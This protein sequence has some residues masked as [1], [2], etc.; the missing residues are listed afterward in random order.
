MDSKIAEVT[1]YFRNK[2][3]PKWSAVFFITAVCIQS[4]CISSSGLTTQESALTPDQLPLVRSL[5][6]AEKMED[7][8]QLNWWKKL[9]DPQLSELITEA[10]ANS[11]DLAAADARA[12][13][14]FA[15][16]NIA[17]AEQYPTLDT[18]AEETGERNSAKTSGSNAGHFTR[19]HTLGLSFNWGIDLWGTQRATWLATLGQ[20]R[21]AQIETVAAR[22]QVSTNVARAYG[23]LAYAYT[24]LDISQSEW[25]RAQRILSLTRQ[26][27]KQGIDNDTARQRAET[28][29]A[30]AQQQILA[31]KRNLTAANSALAALI[32]RG[33]D[34]ALDIQRPTLP[35]FER[36]GLPDD[37]PA[38]LLN[39]RADLLAARWQIESN[40]Q[41][42]KAATSLFLP[43]ISLRALAGVASQGS[44]NLFS[45]ASRN[46]QIAPTINLPIFDGGRLRANL[47]TQ[48]ALYDRAI[49]GYNKTL[50]NALKEVVVLFDASSSF[51]QQSTQQQQVTTLAQHTWQLA[52]QRYKRGVGS[53]LEVLSTQQ[54]LFTAKQ[55]LAELQVQQ[56][57][58]TVQL[59]AALGGGLAPSDDTLLPPIPLKN[60]QPINQPAEVSYE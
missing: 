45:W 19:D 27:L 6:Q 1:L 46:Y 58:N 33:P 24:Q 57:D 38:E 40:H 4:G 23:Q 47:A 5:A 52:Q 21:V 29:V 26:R 60:T 16:A 59:I 8:P 31:A 7:W 41:R 44:T 37:L 9:D 32:G 56:F 15:Q 13:E 36:L 51:S 3:L 43:N 2:L 11:P 14:A 50:I 12:R 49:A 53:Y 54:P 18:S 39:R 22:I 34:R 55:G 48:N 25:Q 20:A 17:A 28:T 10:L 42:I 30:N 35:A